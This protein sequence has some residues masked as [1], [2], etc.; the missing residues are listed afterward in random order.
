MGVWE[1]KVGRERQRERERDQGKNKS[2]GKKERRGRDDKG[3]MRGR[4]TEGRR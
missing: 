2:K 4:E 1:G 3:S